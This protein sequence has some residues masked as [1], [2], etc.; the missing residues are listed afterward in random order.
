MGT[1]RNPVISLLCLTCL[2]MAT[3]LLAAKS[4]K[5]YLLFAG[6]YTQKESKGIYAWR[7]SAVTGKVEALGLAAETVNPS[8]LVVHPSGKTLYA[9]NEVDAFL[10]R[11]SGAVSA[12]S[13]DR[14]TGRLMLLNQVASR[15][16]DPC[17]LALNRSGRH[18]FVANYTGGN[19]AVLP[20]EA[21]GRLK[22]ASGFVQ[23]VGTV[24]DAKRQG[25][26]HA[27]A[28]TLSPDERFAFVADLGLDRIFSYRFDAA[29]GTLS[30]N[31]VP[32]AR[33]APVAGPRHFVFH[34]AGRL[35]YAINELQS[36]V[37]A[38]AFD[39]KRGAL[40]E[41]Q[42]VSTLPADAKGENDC[43]EI[44]IHPNGR[45][46]FG[47]N[48][49]HDSIAV[50]GIGARG[51][52]THLG[53]VPTGGRTPRHIA[54]DPTGAYLFAENQESN[55]VVLFRVDA[56]TGRLTPTGVTFPVAAP[57]CLAFLAVE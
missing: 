42:T 43:A 9:V 18:L 24:V 40:L 20:I 54:L 21:D 49:G 12:F 39:S 53:S 25:A 4:A 10:G 31:E 37:T 33:V 50:F 13:V 32:F 1:M 35:A 6:T 47:S 16:A 15:G 3:P 52:L 55:N 5:S 22:E 34:P 38:F 28:V 41:L 57:V 48:R 17:H 26:P 44:L 29:K 36:S 14:A 51:H 19:V 2:A 8:Y 11:K 46:L 27:H 56:K 30:P 23:H 7:F 45:L